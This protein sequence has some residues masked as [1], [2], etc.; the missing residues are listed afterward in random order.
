[1]SVQGKADARTKQLQDSVAD[2][3]TPLPEIMYQHLPKVHQSN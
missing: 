2:N 3:N 1:M